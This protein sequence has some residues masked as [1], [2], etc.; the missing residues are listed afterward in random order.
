MK[1]RWIPICAAAWLSVGLASCNQAGAPT[2]ASVQTA[3]EL[4]CGFVPIA[5]SISALFITGGNAALATTAD[6]AATILCNAV[7]KTHPS[8]GR[9]GVVHVSVS[10][11]GQIIHVAGR[12]TR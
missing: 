2:V 11:Q 7:T 6:E 10:Y 12:F 1:I 3:T 5:A 4:L 9:D 8:A